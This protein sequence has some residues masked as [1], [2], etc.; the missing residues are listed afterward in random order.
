MRPVA[1]VLSTLT[2]TL[3]LA[4][5]APAAQAAGPR[6]DRGERSLV[7][8]INHARARYGLPRL[9]PGGRLSHVADAHTRS[10]LAGDYFSHGAFVARV[11]RYVS[12]HRIGE[13]LAM[14]SRCGAHRF[15]SMWLN[16]PPHREVLLSR[17]FRRIGVGRR[18]GNLAGRRACM[19]TADFAS[20]R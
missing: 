12:F 19:V 9:H 1:L 5:A 10:M 4:T 17:S 20:R 8:A 3:V 2:T 13:T 14:S 11:R 6:L 16:S 15:V 18:V 7:R